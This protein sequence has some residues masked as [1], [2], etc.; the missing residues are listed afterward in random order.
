MPSPFILKLQH[1][2]HLTDA[3]RVRL[4]EVCA[5]TRQVGSR[6]DLIQEGDQPD[7]VHLILEGVA[8]RYKMLQDGRRSIMALL[9]PGD[10]C[11]LHIAILGEMDHGIAT[12]SPC[13]VVRIARHTVEEL[14]Q[15][16]AEITRALWW[17]TLVDEAILREWLVSMGQRGADQRTAHLFCELL[18]RLQAVGLADANSYPLW[19]TQGELADV[20]ALSIVH[21]NRT[22]QSLR[23]AN[24]IELDRR[25]LTIPDVE[26]LKGFAGFTARYLH[27]AKPDRSAARGRSLNEAGV[28]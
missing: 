10:F 13:T 21:M 20:L 12:I 7:G 15:H 18:V 26:R 17:A 11:D 6:H 4:E 22:L 16:H 1:G 2:A 3:D 19:L 9:L 25:R 28:P 24:L 5:H 23:E 8:C 14:T 27:L